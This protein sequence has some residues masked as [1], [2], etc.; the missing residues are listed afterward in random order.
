[1]FVH[2]SMDCDRIMSQT[3]FPIFG[4]G[5]H[6]RLDF[7][8]LG[9]LRSVLPKHVHFVAT[10]ATAT[11]ETFH[12]VCNSLFLDKPHVVALPPEKSNIKYS[13]TMKPDFTEFRQMLTRDLLQKR[14]EFL[15]TLIFCNRYQECTPSCSSK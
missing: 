6:F 5:D 7:S 11:L 13:V 9:Q 3:A 1:M 14:G 12:I 10:S 2:A 15:K 8:L 4:R